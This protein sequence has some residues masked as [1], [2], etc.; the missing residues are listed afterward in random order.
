MD[1]GLASTL[2][3]SGRPPRPSR[4]LD[5]H[6]R[7][8]GDPE[9][10]RPIR[11]EA[12]VDHDLDRHALHHLDEVAGGVLRREGGELRDRAELYTVDT[13]AQV[14]RRIS[15]ALDPDL[16]PRPHVIELTFLEVR[17]DPDFGR[18]DRKD[19]LAGGDVIADLDITLGDPAVLRRPHL[20][21]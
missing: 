19:L 3:P 9:R 4:S 17:G 21:P 20:G 1:Y 14:E 6:R 16:L 8:D 5:G 7:C 10:Q 12:G 2:H 11:V 15:V 13:T 18:D